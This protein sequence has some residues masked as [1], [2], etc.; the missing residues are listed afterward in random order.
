MSLGKSLKAPGWNAAALR[1]NDSS[2]TD[3]IAHS[4]IGLCRD[5]AGLKG[6][7]RENR[8]KSNQAAC[9]CVEKSAAQ[10][11]GA[12][13]CHSI[14]K[15]S[16]SK[17]DL[18]C[19]AGNIKHD[20]LIIRFWGGENKSVRSSN[21]LCAYFQRWQAFQTA[22]QFIHA[23]GPLHGIAPPHV[24]FIVFNRSRHGFGPTT[25][26]AVPIRR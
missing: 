1:L 4:H 3:A 6:L 22:G 7:Y 18:A 25:S 5:Q 14:L 12:D 23:Y 9:N 2:W 17:P 26:H 21:A 10:D 15:L 8:K 16:Q 20:I 19:S 24:A 13:M 11:E